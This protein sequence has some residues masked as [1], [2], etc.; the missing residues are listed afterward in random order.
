MAETCSKDFDCSNPLICFSDGECGCH[1]FYGMAGAGCTGYS[2]QG[3]LVLLLASIT[4]LLSLFALGLN[5]KVIL[6][7]RR[8]NM[9]EWNTTS[10]T[11]AFTTVSLIGLVVWKSSTIA[12]L[13]LPE[14]HDL[15]L[16]TSDRK[17]HR[18]VPLEKVFQ[19]LAVMFAFLASINIVVK[20][21]DIA[22]RSQRLL[23]VQGVWGTG[24][25]RRIYGFMGLFILALI[26]ASGIG[27]SEIASAAGIP[28]VIVL[29]LSYVYGVFKMGNI[30]NMLANSL[31]LQDGRGSPRL[32][33]PSSNVHSTSSMEPQA[34]SEL[35]SKMGEEDRSSVRASV[36]RNVFNV[37]RKMSVRVSS[38]RP[39]ATTEPKS[40]KVH[41]FYTL[42]QRIR[43]TAVLIVLAFGLLILVNAYY[44]VMQLLF[45]F[46]EA[47][48][49]REP[50]CL[51]GISFEL[52]GLGTLAIVATVEKYIHDNVKF[53]IMRRGRNQSSQSTPAPPAIS[54]PE[55]PPL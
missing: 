30:L 25:T 3:F 28:F 14:L 45:G 2:L 1:V 44:A 21:L 34:D 23:R 27:D 18:L 10:A 6:R 13:L 41:E 11:L 16:A 32:V 22:A 4:L 12:I 20:W 54:N 47:C 15:K 50:V 17:L 43:T 9:R 42:L 46:R 24:Y 8:Y 52:I 29:Q 37:V 31:K 26:I 39:L 33:M 49:P 35:S 38:A 55:E 5:I 53:V 51:I 36:G 40:E 19:A 7:L 48:N